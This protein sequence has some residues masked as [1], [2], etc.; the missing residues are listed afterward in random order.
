VTNPPTTAFCHEALFYEGGLAG[1][2]D[3]LGP[4]IAT[5]LDAGGSVVV[6]APSDRLVRLASEFGTT[7]RMEL[8]DMPAVGGNPARIIPAWRDLADR[9]HA[10]GGPFLGIGEPIWAGRSAA[11]LDECHRHEALINVAFDADP[12]WRLICPYDVDGLD[13]SVVDDARLTH[14]TVHES[15]SCTSRPIDGPSAFAAL[16]RPLS[17]VPADATTIRFGID[18]LPDLR[19]LARRVATSAGLTAERVDDLTLSIGEMACNA[20]RH[21]QPPRTLTIWSAPGVVTCEASNLGEVGDVLVG[22]RRPVPD[23]L[24][25]R[26]VWIM[27]QLCDLVQIRSVNDQTVVR[28][29]VS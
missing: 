23:Q 4:L 22:R 29:T 26:G 28:L 19:A 2:A 24:S 3:R 5:T 10:T 18:D 13:P 12:A 20:I 11:E 1:F 9:A 6:A 8:I 17:P 25:G 7:D 14:P 27:H 16:E 15:G 21:G